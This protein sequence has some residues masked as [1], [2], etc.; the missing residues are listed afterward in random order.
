MELGIKY[1]GRVATTKDVELINK[2]IEEYPADSRRALSVKFCKATN[3]VQAN[4][5]L[6]DMV[7]RGF[8]LKLYRAGYINLPQKKYSTHNPLAKPKK[9]TEIAIEK[10]P[11][12]TTFKDIGPL[13][14]CQ[15]RRSS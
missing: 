8:M 4:G 2:L 5:A 14:F 9:P 6:R 7:C 11:I 3:W 12:I 13:E 15:V 10:T 1:R